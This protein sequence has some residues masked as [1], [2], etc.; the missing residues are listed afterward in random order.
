MEDFNFLN[1][2][3]KN[4]SLAMAAAA[5]AYN[6]HIEQKRKYTGEPYFNHLVDVGVMLHWAGC[7]SQTIA[8]G[9]MHDI[10]EDQELTVER[11]TDKFGSEVAQLVNE[12][13]DVS[14]PS[15][16][17]RR[18]RKAL[19]RVH[20]AHASPRGMSIKLADIISNTRSIREHDKNFAVVFLSENRALMPLLTEG[21]AL[22]YKEA[23][24][25]VY[26]K[27]L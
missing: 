5:F 27:Y 25:E 8:A 7:D 16:G 1:N 9:F 24:K 22:L 21:N 6:A 14:K 2:V 3:F 4:D 26:G 18:I 15:D 11:L 10:I 19:D 13:S 20:L 12:V 17:N 23:C